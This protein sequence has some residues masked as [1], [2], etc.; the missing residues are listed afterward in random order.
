MREIL[1]SGTI[2]LDFLIGGI[3]PVLGFPCCEGP[4]GDNVNVYVQVIK[5]F[6]K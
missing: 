6:R 1:I 4:R 5:L 3:I 2:G